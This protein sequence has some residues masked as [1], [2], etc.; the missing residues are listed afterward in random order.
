MLLVEYSTDYLKYFSF[1]SCLQVLMFIPMCSCFFSAVMRW[2]WKSWSCVRTSRCSARRWRRP[3]TCW[4]N[5]KGCWRKYR[6]GIYDHL[7]D[8]N[9]SAEIRRATL[10]ISLNYI[11][12]IEAYLRDDARPKTCAFYTGGCRV[13]R[14]FHT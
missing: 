6:Y 3:R 7:R 2:S 9:V 5:T 1:L 10:G 11:Y 13:I 4:L 8:G 14:F 12:R